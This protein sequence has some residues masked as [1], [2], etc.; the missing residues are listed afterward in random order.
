MIES[1]L[2]FPDVIGPNVSDSEASQVS[3][4]GRIHPPFHRRFFVCLLLFSLLL[5]QFPALS[6][7]EIYHQLGIK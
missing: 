2:D 3:V 4:A 5:Q 7:R 1:L 6:W